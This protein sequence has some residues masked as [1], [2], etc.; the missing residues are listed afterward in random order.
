MIIKLDND[1]LNT[2]LA[3]LRVYQECNYG[4]PAFRP[5]R[6]NDIAC[7]TI[8]DTS[9]DA[10]AIDVLCERLNNVNTVSVDLEILRQSIPCED[11]DAWDAWDRICR[12]LNA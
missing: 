2:V 4:D 8:G 11:N 12:T 5:D 1:E 10:E 3:A 6:I 9:L 7:P